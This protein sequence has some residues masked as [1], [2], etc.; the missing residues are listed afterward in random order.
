MLFCYYDLPMVKPISADEENDHLNGYD[1][2]VNISAAPDGRS[3]D[4]TI[5]NDTITDNL[6]SS[7]SVIDGEKQKLVNVDATG[8]PRQR[9]KASVMDKWH[10]AK[11]RHESHTTE[12]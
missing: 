3:Y 10:L 7:G 5:A 6:T 9:R 8:L 1:H 12:L 4:Y 2:S 11:G